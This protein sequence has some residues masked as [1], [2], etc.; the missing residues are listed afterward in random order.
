MLIYSFNGYKLLVISWQWKWNLQEFIKQ[1]RGYS[2]NTRS[3]R[4]VVSAISSGWSVII[5]GQNMLV[6]QP[7]P[8]HTLLPQQALSLRE[9]TH[10][11]P[12]GLQ[13]F[14]ARPLKERKLHRF[15]AK[16]RLT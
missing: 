15:R 13:P 3:W 1:H 10:A 16:I 7:P 4:F 5:D 6:R 11:L 8:S 14:H 12:M 9:R 2:G